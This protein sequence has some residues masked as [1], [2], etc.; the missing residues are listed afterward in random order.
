MMTYIGII[1]VVSI[2]FNASA[3]FFN[4]KNRDGADMDFTEIESGSEKS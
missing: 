1:G 3:Y 2:L 4:Y